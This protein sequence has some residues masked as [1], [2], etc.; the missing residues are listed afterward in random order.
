MFGPGVQCV[1]QRRRIA[2]AAAVRDR[3]VEIG[4]PPG[5]LEPDPRR[6]AR[7]AQAHRAGRMAGRRVREHVAAGLDDLVEIRPVAGPLEP[8]AE[9]AG[10]VGLVTHPHVLPGGPRPDGPAQFPAAIGRAPR[11]DGG[12]YRSAAAGPV[13]SG[14]ASS[15]RNGFRSRSMASSPTRGAVAAFSSAAPAGGARNRAV[16]P[17]S[18]GVIVRVLLSWTAADGYRRGSRYPLRGA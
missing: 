15:A 9:Q 13:S 14:P 6:H 3:G 5:H 1:G 7:V 17:G 8:L 16:R 10:Q 18:V 12:A 4:G 11:R 2:G